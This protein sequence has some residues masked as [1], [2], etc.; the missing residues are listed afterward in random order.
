M[1]LV[2]EPEGNQGKIKANVVDSLL[3][4]EQFAAV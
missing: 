3:G 4:I 2:G 1:I